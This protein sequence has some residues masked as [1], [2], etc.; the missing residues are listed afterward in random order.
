MTKK[1]RS[2]SANN[3]S[4]AN[5]Q[6][7]SEMCLAPIFLPQF[8]TEVFFSFNGQIL[9]YFDSLTGKLSTKLSWKFQ[10]TVNCFLLWHLLFYNFYYPVKFFNN[11]SD[12][13]NDDK[14]AQLMNNNNDNGDDHHLNNLFFT[15]LDQEKIQVLSCGISK[16]LEI[17][18]LTGTELYRLFMCVYCYNGWFIE[19]LDCFKSKV[20]SIY[21]WCL[22]AIISN[23]RKTL[24][25]KRLNSL[26][27]T[28]CIYKRVC[29]LLSKNLSS[30]I[31]LKQFPKHNPICLIIFLFF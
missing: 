30:F 26:F 25:Q 9:I 17:G 21:V 24:G 12:N 3:C 22:T 19:R 23:N 27:L 1:T 18:S 16:D 5:K 10:L 7:K 6:K 2:F 14:K 29:W 8:A 31:V 4:L 11:N 13:S 15:L 20:S 28:Y